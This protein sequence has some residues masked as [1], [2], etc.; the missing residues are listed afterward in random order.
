MAFPALCILLIVLPGIIYRQAYTRGAVP[1]FRPIGTRRE[2]S[3]SKY[4]KSIRSLPEE[5]SASLFAAILLNV[6]WLSLATA[7]AKSGLFPWKSPPNYDQFLYLIY[8]SLDVS[9][10][11]YHLTLH[12]LAEHRL[13]FVGYFLSLYAASSV[14]ARFAL[15]FVRALRLDHHLMF[16]RLEDQWFYFLRGEIFY[17]SEF[18][19]FVKMKDP[20]S[21]TYVSL[22]VDQGGDQYLYKGFLWDFFLDRHGNLDRLVL[23]NVIRS[24]FIPE[25]KGEIKSAKEGENGP[26]DIPIIDRRWTFERVS[27]QIFTVKYADCKT[28]ACTYFYIREDKN[29]KPVEGQ[30]EASPVAVAA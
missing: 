28:L 22:V 4:P 2:N 5:I 7:T 13:E 30:S 17:F 9:K 10:G 21:G 16:L 24:R 19:K 12:Y 26:V 1:I 11:R 25:E 6:I 27:S 23:H 29:E 3:I 20:I 14:I 8:G 15:W 18:R